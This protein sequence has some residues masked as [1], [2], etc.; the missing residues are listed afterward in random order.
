MELEKFTQRACGAVASAQSLALR[1]GNPQITPEH[2]LKVL[3][4]DPEGLAAGLIDRSGGRSRQALPA[5]EAAL[6][7]LP[8]VS[9]SG[10]SQPSAAPGLI[11]VFETAEQVAAKAGD[12]FVTRETL[13]LALSLYK[14]SAVGAI[15]S[16]VGVTPQNLTGSIK[17]LRKGRAA[18]TNNAEFEVLKRYAKDLNHEVRHQ[19]PAIVGRDEEI[20]SAIQILSR[21][22]KNSPVLVGE[23][24]VGKNTVV[25]GLVQRIINGDVPENLRG[26]TVMALDTNA[27]IAG[28]RFPGELEARLN[29]VLLEVRCSYGKVILFIDDIHELT[30]G[31]NRANTLDATSILKSALDDGELQCIG[32]T[33]PSRYKKYIEKDPALARRLQPVFVPEPSVEESIAILRGLKDRYE[34]Y[35][36]VRIS[37]AALVAAATL[38]PRYR[39]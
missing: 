28:A 39:R 31:D 17:E 20:R 23:A 13:L 33:T 1:N 9:G 5:V 12:S 26:K 10:A 7:K 8:K 32:I 14:E 25:K 11:W 6:A 16:S 19:G 3:L 34:A 18:Q 37:D 38:S 4:A 35:Q 27:L 29:A 22:S 24:G 36:R 21:R 30:G 15:L 2:L